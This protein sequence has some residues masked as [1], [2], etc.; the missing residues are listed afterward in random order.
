MWSWPKLTRFLDTGRK[1]LGLYV[2]IEVDLGFVWVV[3]I[4][5]NSVRGIKLDLFQ[6]EESELCCFASG[7]RKRLGFCIYIEIDLDSV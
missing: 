4:Y 3:D 2:C 1:S 5:Y 7:G 6:F